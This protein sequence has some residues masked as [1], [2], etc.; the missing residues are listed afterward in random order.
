MDWLSI[1]GVSAPRCWHLR[2]PGKR[3]WRMDGWLRQPPHYS[4]IFIFNH[5]S[6]F[7]DDCGQYMGMWSHQQRGEMLIW[8]PF[9][10]PLMLRFW[11]PKRHVSPMLSSAKTHQS[12]LSAFSAMRSWR[13]DLATG[14]HENWTQSLFLLPPHTSCIAHVIFST[15]FIT[16]PNQQAL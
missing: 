4:A 3:V 7:L 14:C 15:K 5:A 10:H 2:D 11:C 1:Q 12:P 9:S 8:T 13:E 6:H 16:D